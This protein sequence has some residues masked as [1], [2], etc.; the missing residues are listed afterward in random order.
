M[1]YRISILF[2]IVTMLACSSVRERDGGTADQLSLSFESLVISGEGNLWWA[3]TLADINA[4]GVLDVVL[5]NNNGSGGW[6]GYLKGQIEAGNWS[7]V[8]VAET[9]P[10]GETFASGDLEVADLDGDGDIDLLAVAHPG[11]WDNGSQEATLYWYEQAGQSWVPHLIGTTPSFPKDISIGDLDGDGSPEIIT[12]TFDAATLSVFTKKESYQEAWSIPV[13]NLHEGMDIGDVDGDGLIDIVANGYVLSNPGHLA[14]A[15]TAVSI[16]STWHNQLENHW[17]RNATKVAVRDVDSDGR[18]EVFIGH[19]EK[20]GYPLCRYDWEDDE[21]QKKVLIKSLP[22]AHNLKIEDFDQDGKFDV[23][24]GVNRNRAIDISKENGT[25]LPNEF[26]VM[27]LRQTMSGWETDTIN[28]DGSYNLITGDLEGDGDIDV[29]RMT[30]H[31][32]KELWLMRNQSL[33]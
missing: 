24:T 28:T 3:R 20:A 30:S 26:P 7:K 15:W 17:S 18:S 1:N 27:I 6:F 10:N 31:D 33:K 21:W 12:A 11:E 22:A 23:I 9:A 2:V 4:D 29:F 25:V 14:K 5:I 32:T 13:T 8:I 16:D 19:S